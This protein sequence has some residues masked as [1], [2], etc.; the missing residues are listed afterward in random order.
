MK[1]VT[2][3]DFLKRRRVRKKDLVIV[4]RGVAPRSCGLRIANVCRQV[5][6]GQ[7]RLIGKSDGL[8]D[9]IF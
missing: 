8:L 4:L 5:V 3:F 2:L 7:Y 9:A 6:R 1:H